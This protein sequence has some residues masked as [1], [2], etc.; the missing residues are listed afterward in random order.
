M[1]S[2]TYCNSNEVCG[3]VGLYCNIYQLILVPP[4]SCK[5]LKRQLVGLYS[6]W[7]KVIPATQLNVKWNYIIYY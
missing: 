3:F 6:P 4:F 2:K 1:Y 5:K 7:L